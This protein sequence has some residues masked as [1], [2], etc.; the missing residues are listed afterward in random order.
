MALLWYCLILGFQLLLAAFMLF[1]LIA[2]ITGG[3]FVPSSKTATSAMVKL[4]RLKPGMTIYDIG[5]GDGRLL[6]EAARQKATAVGIEINPYLVLFSRLRAFFGPYKGL[7]RV[8]WRDLWKADISPA[9]VVFV[10][11]LPW[12]MEQLADKLK[13]ELKTGAL[14]VTNSFIFPGWKILRQDNR[15]HVYMYRI[16]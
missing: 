4:A 12:R 1:L 2:F 5:S 11:L 10:Y 8:F 7:V 16:P 14:V 13:R 15:H 6:F 3:P 9:D